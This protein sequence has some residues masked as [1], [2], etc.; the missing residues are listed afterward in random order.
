MK[1]LIALTLVALVTAGC[2]SKRPAV[3]TAPSNPPPTATVEKPAWLP[4]TLGLLPGTK[5]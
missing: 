5:T 3:V 1:Q 2:A 4:P